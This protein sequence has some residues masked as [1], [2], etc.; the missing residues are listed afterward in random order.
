MVPT[1][2]NKPGKQKEH[3]FLYW[4][5]HERGSKQ[6]VRMGRWKG[7]RLGASEKLELYDLKTDL[8]ETKNVAERHPDVVAKIE[9]FLATARTESEFWNLK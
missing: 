3:A 4:E 6:A 5:F 9:S 2:L 1:L 7:G 8:G